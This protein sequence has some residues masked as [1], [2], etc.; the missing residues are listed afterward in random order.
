MK[1][2]GKIKPKTPRKRR[3]WQRLWKKAA[4]LPRRIW[5][6]GGVAALVIVI[7]WLLLSPAQR[8][9]PLPTPSP[10]AARTEGGALYGTPPTSPPLPEA[11]IPEQELAFIEA[12]HLQPTRPTRMDSLQA[13]VAA[14]PDAPQKLAYTYQ[15]KV[16]DRVIPEAAEST[17]ILTPFKKGDMISVTVTPHDG[18]TE[19]LAVESPLVA[20]HSIAPSLELKAMRQTR[21]PGEP[22]ELQLVGVAPDGDQIAFSLEPPLVSGMTIDRRSGKISWPLQPDQKGFFRFGAAVEDDQ[23]TKVTKIFDITVE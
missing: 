12:V 14:A 8:E 7:A 4:A 16:N 6:T 23:G 21:K 2:T 3:P 10:G 13:E 20:V 1:P 17:L 9:A 22:I 15:W 18:T 11:G 19:G 5:V